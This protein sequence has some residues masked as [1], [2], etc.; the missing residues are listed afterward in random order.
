MEKK[1]LKEK[2]R[3]AFIRE[4]TKQLK[5]RPRH[6]FDVPGHF[7]VQEPKQE[8]E[9]SAADQVQRAAEY[10]A[11]STLLFAKRQHRRNTFH[12]E[13][14]FE[15]MHP[16]KELLR[17]ETVNEY[18]K[19]AES[20]AEKPALK[21]NLVREKQSPQTHRKDPE[22][23]ALS[24]ANKIRGATCLALLATFFKTPTSFSLLTEDIPAFLLIS[25]QIAAKKCSFTDL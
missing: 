23:K 12:R 14:Y 10:A 24:G 16:A 21:R 11:H 1:Y 13:T 25:F 2:A 8:E 19:K 7:A 6:T 5:E 22:Q 17:Q 15:D 4:R 20:R 9:S 18:K 3:Y